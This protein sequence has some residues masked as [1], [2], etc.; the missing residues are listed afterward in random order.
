MEAPGPVYRYR[1]LLSLG[2]CRQRLAKTMSAIKM[3]SA[4]CLDM[5]DRSETASHH[6]DDEGQSGAE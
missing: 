1:Q 6:D 2:L 3:P 4:S 5:P